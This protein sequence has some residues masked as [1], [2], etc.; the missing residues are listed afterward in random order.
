MIICLNCF[1]ESDETHGMCPFCGV[2]DVRAAAPSHLVP[3]V[4][5]HN[6]RYLI[7]MAI[8][9]G[10]FDV[11]YKAYDTQTKAVVAVKEFF[12]N[13]LSDRPEGTTDLIV[14]DDKEKFNR[15]KAR[16]LS[17]AAISR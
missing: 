8:S 4:T 13:D 1:R 14:A 16:F 3:G 9:S 7:G 6:D 2:T 11:I 12:P 10:K 5:L 15:E 17:E